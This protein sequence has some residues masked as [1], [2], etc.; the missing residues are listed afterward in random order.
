M[1]V[2]ADLR[3]RP[4]N[5]RGGHKGG[6]GKEGRHIGLPLQKNGESFEI[7]N[8]MK[9]G[10]REEGEHIGSPLWPVPLGPS[11]FC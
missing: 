9:R 3:V 7:V 4:E 2:G 6:E 8:G 1:N 5:H 10:G 11:E